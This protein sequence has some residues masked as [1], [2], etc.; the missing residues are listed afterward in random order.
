M[1]GPRAPQAGELGGHQAHGGQ[2]SS[3]RSDS[4]EAKP[5]EHA[6]SSSL[7][8]EKA[9]RVDKQASHYASLLRPSTCP[10]NQ[11]GPKPPR[12]VR[13]SLVNSQ[14][15]PACVQ[16]WRFDQARYNATCLCAALRAKQ[17]KLDDTAFK[18]CRV[19]ATPPAQPESNWCWNARVQARALYDTQR[20]I[21]HY[22]GSSQHDHEK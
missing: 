19:P 11:S 10:A 21:Y 7:T 3:S 6:L 14:F 4:A 20:A 17:N 13:A 22:A 12:G 2:L 5:P 16:A 1:H 18:R 9:E 8:I 15:Q